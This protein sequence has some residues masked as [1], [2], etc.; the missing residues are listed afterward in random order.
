[1]PKVVASCHG[2]IGHDGMPFMKTL[3]VNIIIS[4]V[5]CVVCSVGAILLFS[6][7]FESSMG[8]VVLESYLYLPA[9]ISPLAYFIGTLSSRNAM[10]K[11]PVCGRFNTVYKL[12]SSEDFGE[13]Q[14][15]QHTEYDY[16]S[17]RVG[18]K[19][20]KTY[21]TDGT[22]D[23][24]SEGIYERVRYA[25]EYNDYSNLA[26]YTYLCHECSYT[27]ET[28]EEKKWKTLQARHRG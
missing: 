28:L 5:L 17:E 22:V 7:K 16:E 14:D 24:K 10:I 20:T 13:R 27:E 6:D 3:T 1:M 18:T 25:N 21:Y 8:L 12:K 4:A 23:T 9:V 15:G 19:T 2:E 26:K 11:C